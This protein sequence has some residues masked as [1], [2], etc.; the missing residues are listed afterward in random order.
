MT[1]KKDL[2][3]TALVVRNPGIGV[4]SFSSFRVCFSSC[5]SRA[6]VIFRMYTVWRNVKFDDNGDRS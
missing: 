1:R 4:S 5:K 3:L 6:V 2:Y